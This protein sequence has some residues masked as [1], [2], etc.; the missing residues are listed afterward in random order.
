MM[1]TAQMPEAD[2]KLLATLLYASLRGT[3]LTSLVLD[4]RMEVGNRYFK[5]VTKR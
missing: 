5:K 3:G 4:E 1:C 2:L